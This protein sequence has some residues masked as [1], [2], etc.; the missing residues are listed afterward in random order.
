MFSNPVHI[1]HHY[2]SIPSTP[3][4]PV[5][6]PLLLPLLPHLPSILHHHLPNPT[7]HMSQQLQQRFFPRGPRLRRTIEASSPVFAQDVEGG[8]VLWGVIG[9]GDFGSGR[10]IGRVAADDAG[11]GSGGVEDP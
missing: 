3:P 5:P 9:G 4:P 11:W 6:F 10:W 1:P 7:L 8:T 2:P